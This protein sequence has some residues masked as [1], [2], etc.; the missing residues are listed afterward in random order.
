MM[1]RRLIAWVALAFGI[2]ANQ[3]GSP[4]TMLWGILF[5]VLLGSHSLLNVAY[6]KHA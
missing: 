3:L 1:V 6:H 5:A 2:V 4:G